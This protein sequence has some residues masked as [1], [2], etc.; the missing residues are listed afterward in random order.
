MIRIKDEKNMG[1][2]PHS[3]ALLIEASRQQQE[4]LSKKERFRREQEERL[5][6]QQQVIELRND[7]NEI[8]EILKGLASA[9]K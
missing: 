8:K 5:S 7:M 6:L 2:D 1:R 3:K 4:Y 9:I